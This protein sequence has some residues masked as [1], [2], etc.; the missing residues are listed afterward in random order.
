MER[1]ARGR[2][3]QKMSCPISKTRVG[4]VRAQGYGVQ[5]ICSAESA[6]V[7]GLPVCEMVGEFVVSSLR[8]TL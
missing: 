1:L 5:V 7:T 2:M 8:L 3:P 6:M 4:F